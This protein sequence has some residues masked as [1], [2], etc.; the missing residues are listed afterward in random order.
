MSAAPRLTSA[1]LVLLTEEGKRYELIEG[2]LYVSKQ[3]HWHHQFACGRVFAALQ[4][5]SD[6]TGF[7]MANIAPG[8]IFADDDD[9]AP[10]VVWSSFGRL[11]A[12]LRADGK[13]YG[14]PEL[15]VEVLSPG[16]ENER[17]DREAKLK[18]YARR[19]VQEYWII[20]WRRRLIEVYRREQTTLQQ[21]A[22][23]FATDVVT[24]PLLPGFSYP[25]I[26]LFISR[27][28]GQPN[29]PSTD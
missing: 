17:R 29:G 24:S 13:L 2:E 23:L 12:G 8:L 1:D 9:V 10:D 22:T 27:P 3:P 11:D 28:I 14:A 21:M 15:V 4:D 20:D 25:V 7:G 26:K 16:A 19:G 5:W 18:L 6:T